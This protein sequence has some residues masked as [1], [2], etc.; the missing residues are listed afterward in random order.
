MIY[1][2]WRLVKPFTCEY[3]TLPVDSEITILK[4]AIYFNGGMV[5]PLFYDFFRDFINKEVKEPNYLREVP[6]PYNKV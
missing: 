1:K 6:I 2:R 4:E 5:N 3:G